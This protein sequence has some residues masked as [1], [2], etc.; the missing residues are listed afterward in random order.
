MPPTQLTAVVRHIH[1]LADRDGGAPTDAHLLQRYL[2]WHDEA[3]FGAIV[4]RHGRMV[5]RVCRGVLHS[6]HDAEDAFQATFLVLARSAASIRAGSSLSSWLYGV[7]YRV[8]RNARRASDRRQAHEREARPVAHTRTD[9]DPALR[10]LQ[11]ILAEEVSRLPQTYRAAFVL[12]CLEG[13]SKAEAAAQLG[14]KEGTVSGRLARARERIRQRLTRRGL[15]L[16]AVLCAGALSAD[17][18]LAVPPPLVRTTINAALGTAATG[19]AAGAIPARVADLAEGVT[20]AM[21]VNRVR[22]VTVL[23]LAVGVVAAGAGVLIC[24]SAAAGAAREAAPPAAATASAGAA[25]AD[26]PR[27]EAP[28]AAEVSGRVL[29]PDGRPLAGARL[30]LLEGDCAGKAP[31]AVRA[32]TDDDGRFRLTPADNGKVLFAAA[33][34]CGP[35]WTRDFGKPGEVTLRLAKDDVPITGRVVDLEGRPLAGATVRLQQL[36]APLQGTL[37]AWLEARKTRKDGINLEFEYLSVLLAPELPQLYPTATTDKDG[38]FRL[39]GV[40]RER[41]ATLLIEEPAIETGQVNVLTRAGVKTVTMPYYDNFPEAGELTYHAAAFDHPAAPCRLVTGV[42]RDRATGRPIAGAAIRAGTPF[43]HLLRTT[44]DKEGRYRLTGLARA[45]RGKSQVILALSPEDAPYLAASKE[46]RVS[47]DAPRDPV[48]INFELKKGVWL[49]G[50]VKDKE[51]RGVEAFLTPFVFIEALDKEDAPALY[52]PVPNDGG[53]TD[54]RGRYRIA[55]FPGRGLVGARATGAGLDR[56]CAG[57]GA[58][59][60]K[61]GGPSAHA[62]C[63][64]YPTYP[65]RALNRDYDCLKE[66]NPAAADKV[67]SC[68]FVLDPGRALTVR[69]QGPDGKGLEGTW[70]FGQLVRDQWSEEPVKEAEFPVHG[71]KPGEGRTL[72]LRHEGKGLAGVVRIGGDERGPVTARLVPAAAVTGRLLDHG[73]RPLGHAAIE[74]RFYLE[75]RPKWIFNHHPLT[76]RAD[77]DGKFRIDGLVPGLKYHALTLLQPL[78]GRPYPGHVFADLVLREGETRDLGDVK[79]KRPDDD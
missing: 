51:G 36:K 58:E 61:G 5:L 77:A 4:R 72:V 6:H 64:D 33:D 50:Q 47:E 69:A 76:A 23:A 41:V 52:L 13:K 10:E 45:Q 57:V 71:L 49:E 67:V 55:V 37:D 30:Y 79:I 34:G 73:G 2:E 24:R 21:F 22:V 40:G 18:A 29:D 44:T 3:A 26:R 42:V 39:G 15:S 28:P 75:E 16:A 17:D 43:N 63:I 9:L 1:Q 20:K 14:W 53:R 56:Y 11:Q 38:R 62:G 66:V 25:T 68:D 27:T 48:S 35:A 65:V 54:G 32:T 46:A 7:A 70:V 8:A 74:V 60:I 78:S 19:A 59:R 12:C 31:P